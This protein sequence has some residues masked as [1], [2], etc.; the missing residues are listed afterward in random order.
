VIIKQALSQ[1]MDA[2]VAKTKENERHFFD[3]ISNLEEK[4]NETVQL[5]IY[6]PMPDCVLMNY[7]T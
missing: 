7:L 2:K 6:L 1:L 5:F 3:F 4:G